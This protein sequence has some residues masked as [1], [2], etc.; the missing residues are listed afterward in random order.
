MRELVWTRAAESD[1]Q[2]I[3][4]QLEN[5]RENVGR[6]FLKLLDAALELL[7]QFPEMAP[8]FDPPLRRLVLNGRKHGIFY[9][10]EP[11]GIILH[12]VADLHRDSEELR[13]RFRRITGTE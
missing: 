12:A 7:R 4:S 11:R 3:Y 1:L 10:L 6:R 2:E 5:A 8:V 13:H 9:T